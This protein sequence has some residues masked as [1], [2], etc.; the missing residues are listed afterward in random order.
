[1][2]RVGSFQ[3]NA[4][5]VPRHRSNTSMYGSSMSRGWT[6]TVPEVGVGGGGEELQVVS[7]VSITID[8][9]AP[10]FIL[11][12]DPNG[13]QGNMLL[14][15]M[16]HMTASA[17]SVTT[18][19]ATASTTPISSGN[20]K[21]GSML[22]TTKLSADFTLSDIFASLYGAVGFAGG[23]SETAQI[24]RPFSI[25]CALRTGS[26]RNEADTTIAVEVLP[27]IRGVLNC[28]KLAQLLV[29]T[30]WKSTCNIFYFPALFLLK[31]GLILLC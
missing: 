12:A 14:L 29:S 9:R 26:V 13:R 23:R 4:A 5:A 16:G 8:M 2:F 21:S 11:P 6:D 19:P 17:T 27:E 22:R 18:I 1:M 7:V 20:A 28:E 24:L 3:Q 31:H 30:C 15:D 10:L 25:K